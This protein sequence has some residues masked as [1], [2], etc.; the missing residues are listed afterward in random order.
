MHS[1]DR[2]SVRVPIE[3][4]ATWVDVRRRLSRTSVVKGIEVNAISRTDA[5][6][7]IEYFGDVQQLSGA[8]G[9]QDLSLTESDGFWV[10]RPLRSSAGGSGQ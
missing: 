5:Q 4:L 2:V 7:V 6:I 3:N 8:L 1:V 9:Q 10:L